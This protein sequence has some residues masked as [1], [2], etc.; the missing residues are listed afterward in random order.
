MGEALRHGAS[1]RDPSGFVYW[2]DGDIYRQ[3]S[4]G[5]TPEFESALESGLLE[6][7]IQDRLLMPFEIV[8]LSLRESADAGMVLQPQRLDW[9]SYPYEW[10]F[11]QWKDAALC[12]LENCRR[13]LEAG[14]ILKDASSFNIQFY[15]GKPILIDTLSFQ[16]YEE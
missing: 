11:G 10:G 7:L 4:K 6:G 2:R 5:F 14:F 1:F 12:T 13:A 16:K 15:R 3:V 9:V 8:D